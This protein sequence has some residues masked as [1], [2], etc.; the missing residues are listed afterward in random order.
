LAQNAELT[1]TTRE[2]ANIAYV[3]SLVFW[4]VLPKISVVQYLRKYISTGRLKFD[5]N[6]QTTRKVYVKLHEK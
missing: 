4:H 1:K 3:E 5:G 6:K 2:I